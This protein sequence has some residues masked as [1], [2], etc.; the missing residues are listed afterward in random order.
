MKHCMVDLETLGTRPGSVIL[1][2]GA[3]FFD[4]AS[5]LLGDSFHQVIDVAS[6]CVAGLKGDHSTIKWWEKQS[7]EARVTY[8]V[9]F[10]TR[11]SANP[12]EP[13]V[14]TLEAFN[15]YL[16]VGGPAEGPKHVRLW[17]NGAAFDNALL[18]E[19]YILANLTLAVPFFNDRCFRTLKALGSEFGVVEPEFE[20]ERHHA[21][22]DA[23]HQA[24][25]ALKVF[26]ALAPSPV[27]EGDKGLGCLAP[28]TVVEVHE[29]RAAEAFKAKQAMLPDPP[30]GYVAQQA[31]GQRSGKT[32]QWPM[33]ARHGQLVAMIPTSTGYVCPTCGGGA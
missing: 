15:S 19:A 11:V 26:E 17:G 12:A 20:G 23:I 21:L 10:G 32:K 9:A 1:S 2:I 28:G 5:G 30:A 8:E 22:A 18:R 27:P 16:A 33:C 7:A 13:L 31:T 3:V 29:E 24:K 14:K 25:W 4:P 6:C